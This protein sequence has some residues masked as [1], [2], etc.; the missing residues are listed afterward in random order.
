[1]TIRGS[2][3]VVACLVVACVSPSTDG[4]EARATADRLALIELAN[5]YAWG[6]D[7]LDRSTLSSVFTE[8][9]VAEYIEV[10]SNVLGMNERLE[11]FAAIWVWLSAGLGDRQG[12]EALPMHYLTNH[13]VELEGAQARIRCFQH[14]RSLAGGGVYTMD[15]VRTDQGW[16]VERLRLEEQI[17]KPEVYGYPPEEPAD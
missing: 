2:S 9:A 15:A 13:M 3:I 6:I 10:G 4:G 14:N 16:R 12:H 11:G 8:D 1:M 7:T 17:W 5:R